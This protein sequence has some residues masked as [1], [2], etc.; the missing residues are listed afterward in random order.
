MQDYI[1]NGKKQ[2]TYNPDLLVRGRGVG[3]NSNSKW[4]RQTGDEYGNVPLTAKFRPSGW[5]KS[6][7]Y[8][9]TFNDHNRG[10]GTGYDLM[11]NINRI[12]DHNHVLST[13][14]MIGIST[15]VNTRKC[16]FCAEVVIMNDENK[17]WKCTQGTCQFNYSADTCKLMYEDF[18]NDKSLNDGH[19]RFNNFSGLQYLGEDGDMTVITRKGQY[20]K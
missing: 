16:P 11:L 18:A 20:Y 1:R 9:L 15:N 12:D 10:S 6:Y 19:R 14:N 7:E 13:R 17:R 4:Y 3:Y 2:S 8:E 5:A